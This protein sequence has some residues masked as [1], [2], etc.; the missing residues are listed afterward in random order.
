MRAAQYAMDSAE[1]VLGVMRIFLSDGEGQT[2]GHIAVV[3]DY[4]AEEKAMLVSVV[5]SSQREVCRVEDDEQGSTWCWLKDMNIN[6]SYL[7]DDKDPSSI[8]HCEAVVINWDLDK[9][10]LCVQFV[11]EQGDVAESEP[12]W[13]SLVEDEWS[14]L[15]GDR[16]P[17][18]MVRVAFKK[19]KAEQRKLAKQQS[20]SNEEP[21]KKSHKKKQ[22]DLQ[23]QQ[24][25]QAQQAQQALQAQQAQQAAQ[26]QAQSKKSHKRK[27]PESQ[28]THQAGGS[29]QQYQTSHQRRDLEGN[30][31]VPKREQREPLFHVESVRRRIRSEGTPEE[32]ADEDLAVLV[33]A[34]SA[35]HSSNPIEVKSGGAYLRSSS[36]H[37][38]VKSL[39]ALHQLNVLPYLVNQMS[40]CDDSDLHQVLRSVRGGRMPV[41]HGVPPPTILSI[42]GRTSHT[43]PPCPAGHCRDT[44]QRITLSELPP[45]DPQVGSSAGGHA[46]DQRAT[47]RRGPEGARACAHAEPFAHT[48]DA[49]RDHR[50]GIYRG[51]A[52]F[53]RRC[54]LRGGRCGGRGGGRGGG[55]SLVWGWIMI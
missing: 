43:Q 19:R 2:F 5:T 26:Q 32:R 47:S 36:T 10:L 23:A 24:M 50:V 38:G 29:G 12:E 53:S 48:A 6:V 11:A 7:E 14:W 3:T 20:G 54:V 34:V 22:S 52:A 15:D 44:D 16:P 25:Q 41:A 9:F 4:D 31:V 39:I 1:T 33:A 55:G 37:G 18:D 27:Q 40:T 13:I 28:Q 8:Y 21:P 46:C 51:S 35:L 42:S 49:W 45:R 17:Q 30:G